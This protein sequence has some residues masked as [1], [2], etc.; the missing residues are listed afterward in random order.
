MENTLFP[1]AMEV[2]IVFALISLIIFGMQFIRL[3]KK[4]YL[5]LAVAIPCSLL[6]Y[7]IPSSSFFYWLGVAEAAAMLVALILAKTVD[8]D[9]SKPQE[10]TPAESA[11]A[12]AKE[13]E[14][15]AAET[16]NAAE[17]AE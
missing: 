2:H 14:E 15:P 3:R 4:Y 17:E 5:V 7:V 16:V 9:K 13:S 10:D 1:I 12:P 8:R 11:E 6:A